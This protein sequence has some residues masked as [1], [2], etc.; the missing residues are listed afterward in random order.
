MAIFYKLSGHPVLFTKKNHRFHIFLD[1]Q[2]LANGTSGHPK[3]KTM[4]K[5]PEE[6]RK[7]VAGN[8]ATPAGRPGSAQDQIPQIRVSFCPQEGME[9][10]PTEK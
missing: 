1:P 10:E 7:S 9:L 5:R 8:E 2:P 3:P 6:N 4:K